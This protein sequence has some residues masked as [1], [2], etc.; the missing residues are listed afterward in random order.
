MQCLGRDWL[1]INFCP[2]K[3]MA[4]QNLDLPK[5]KLP[6]LGQKLGVHLVDCQN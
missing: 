4:S 3:I 6:K 2:T 5:P 1:P